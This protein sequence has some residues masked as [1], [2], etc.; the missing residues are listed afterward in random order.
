MRRVVVLAV[1]ASLGVIAWTFVGGTA[2]VL[3]AAAAAIALVGLLLPPALKRRRG[4]AD[5]VVDPSPSAGGPVPT[6]AHGGWLARPLPGVRRLGFVRELE[7]RLAEQ[8]AENR[9]LH[10]QL[11]RQL[12]ALRHAN[13]LLAQD[14]SMRDR[15]LIRVEHSLR[16]HSRERALLERQLEVIETIVTRA[17][18][19]ALARAVG[20]REAANGGSL[21]P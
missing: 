2:R 18:P 12:E 10:E 15:A 1:L 5:V 21:N 11:E 7:A 4:G 19:P 13:E 6:A 17:S 8:E 16:R 20:A 9:A 14:R 3:Y